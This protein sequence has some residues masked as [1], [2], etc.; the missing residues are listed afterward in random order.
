MLPS[1]FAKA[2]VDRMCKCCQFSV[3]IFNVEWERVVGVVFRCRCRADI[4]FSVL[5]LP[6]SSTF[7]SDLELSPLF[8]FT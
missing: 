3:L 5:P 8:T 4:Y 7:I 2:T 6:L 1:T